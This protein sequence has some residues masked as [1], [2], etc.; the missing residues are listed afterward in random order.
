MPQI[1]KPTTFVKQFTT[2][3]VQGE[4]TI[5]LNL[6]L[7]IKTDSNGNISVA[8]APAPVKTVEK[9][10]EYVSQV[11]DWDIEANDLIDFGKDV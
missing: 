4:V 11:P 7:T 8:A 3:T 1:I 10:I 5:N 9:E 2:N 6:I